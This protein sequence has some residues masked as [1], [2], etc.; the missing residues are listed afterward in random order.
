MGALGLG[1]AG[2]GEPGH[3]D[4]RSESCAQAFSWHPFSAPNSGICATNLPR[5]VPETAAAC[6]K[7]VILWADTFN[8]Y[9]FPETAQ[10]ATEVLEN[11]GCDVHVPE[12]HLCC[13]RPLYDYGFL[14]AAKRYLQRILQTL[15]PEIEAGIPV[16]VLEP[17]CASVF[18]D[19][20]HGLFPYD[21]LANKLH[22]QTFLFS[23]FLEKKAS[24]WQ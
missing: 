5:L 15:Q 11:V 19:E 10:A 4:T 6:S 2:H 24:E 14:D 1:L 20:L 9:F 18:R 8:N 7:K 22:E 21:R 12:S 23:E 16:I 3:A 17:S 13:G